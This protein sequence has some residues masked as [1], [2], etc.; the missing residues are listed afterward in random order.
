MTNLLK[1]LERPEAARLLKRVFGFA[2]NLSNLITSAGRW[3]TE[4]ADA[5]A[6]VSAND[7]L[8]GGASL[9]TGGVDNN[10]ASLFTRSEP[11]KFTD[12][13]PIVLE[14]E[15]KLVEANT[16]DANWLVGLVSGVAADVLQDDGAGPPAN[17]SGAVVFKKD[18]DTAL[19]V[20]SSIGAT[21]TTTLTSQAAASSN[22]RRICIIVLPGQKTD[23]VDIHFFYN[24]KPLEKDDDSIPK[25]FR[26]AIHTGVDVSAATEMSFVVSVKAGGANSETL[27]IRLASPWQLVN[28][29]VGA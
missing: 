12:D 24:D 2:D 28:G 22:W 26:Q 14:A 8:G 5:A 29:I 15:V 3:E 25:S 13:E 17:Y 21:Q 16:D 27:Q 6:S 20:E 10:Q 23:T 11:F 1:T 4:E 9:V 7:A 18:G 19:Y